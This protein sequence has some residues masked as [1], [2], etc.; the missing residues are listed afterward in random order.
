MVSQH[1]VQIQIDRSHDSRPEKIPEQRQDFEAEVQVGSD[2]NCLQ[3]KVLIH[4]NWWNYKA[5]VEASIVLLE[6]AI[7]CWV[8]M[9]DS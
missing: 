2:E 8:S 5:V 9:T 3:K 7:D 6:E 4:W 1:Y